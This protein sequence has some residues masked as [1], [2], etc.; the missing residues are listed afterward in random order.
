MLVS[1]KVSIRK[2]LV[3]N[4]LVEWDECICRE[5]LDLAI[6]HNRVLKILRDN[7]ITYRIIK[8]S[9]TIKK[10]STNNITKQ[11]DDSNIDQN[12]EKGLNE[13]EKEKSRNENDDIEIYSQETPIVMKIKNKCFFE[14]PNPPPLKIHPPLFK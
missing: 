14:G 1:I 13:E 8:S 12:L 10:N 9:S 2:T 3:A 7:K 11:L 6:F 4:E 5:N